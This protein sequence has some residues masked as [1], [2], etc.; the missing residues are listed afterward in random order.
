MDPE[1]ESKI[2]KLRETKARA[3]L[4]GGQERIDRQHQRGKLTARERIDILL[5]PGSFTELNMLLGHA[6]GNAGEGIL[7]GHGNIEG[8]PV[9]IFAQ[10]VTVRNAAMHLQHGLKLYRVMELALNMGVPI[11][12]LDDS[13]GALVPR[14]DEPEELSYEKA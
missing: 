5:D 13:P 9:C 4:G 12:G 7:T 10:D 11:I 6:D 3:R 1:T 14:L 8:R 2:A